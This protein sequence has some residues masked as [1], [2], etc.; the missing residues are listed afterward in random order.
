MSPAPMN[1]LPPPPISCA[2][3]RGLLQQLRETMGRF[4]HTV[5]PADEKHPANHIN[6]DIDDWE[7]I[8][9]VNE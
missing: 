4:P 2:L 9:T 1:K 5:L 6:M 7:D 8:T 3:A